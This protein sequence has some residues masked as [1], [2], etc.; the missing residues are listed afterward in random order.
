MVL[1]NWVEQTGESSYFHY[2]HDSAS[3]QSPSFLKSII[4]FGC[5]EM[6]S[7]IEVRPYK[8]VLDMFWWLCTEINYLPSVTILLR[9]YFRTFFFFL[10][11]FIRRNLL[12]YSCE[13]LSWL[14]SVTH[15]NILKAE[16]VSFSF[17]FRAI[18]T[19]FLFGSSAKATR[20]RDIIVGH[21][22][23]QTNSSIPGRISSI[24]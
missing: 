22:Q 7:E 24:S 2:F 6:F 19:W 4:F 10:L 1:K 5:R 11:W 17:H 13:H 14:I 12:S 15:R 20:P 3:H 9:V 18:L 8:C 16:M 21:V 23:I